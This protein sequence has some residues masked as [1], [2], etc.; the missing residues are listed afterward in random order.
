MSTIPQ[1]L[2]WVE[3]RA[4]CSADQVFRELQT[5]IENDIA[6]RNAIRGTGPLVTGNFI[7]QLTSD[8]K[9]LIVA[10][11]GPWSKGRLKIFAMDG[12]IEVRNEIANTN[13]AAKVIF[14]D[15]GR[16]K[17]KLEDDGRELEQW[18]FRKLALESLFFGD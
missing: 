12:R 4:A 9:V 14:S 15:E 7:A 10:E 2:N 6:Y 17:L 3:K 8:G 13:W 1:D 5:G 18:Q 11:E 16:C